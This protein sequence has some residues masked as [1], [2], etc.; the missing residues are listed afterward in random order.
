[1]PKNISD[2]RNIINGSLDKQL[3]GRALAQLQLLVNN[4][5]SERLEEIKNTYRYL[6]QYILLER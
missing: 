1:M 4:A 5:D 3:L 6:L 2:I